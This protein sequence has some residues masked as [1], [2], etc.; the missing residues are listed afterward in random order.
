[1]PL[2]PKGKLMRS[3][4]HDACS[5]AANVLRLNSVSLMMG[6]TIGRTCSSMAGSGH[7]VQ[8]ASDGRQLP[9]PITR[10]Y[11]AS[12]LSRNN[13]VRKAASSR[14]EGNR[15]PLEMARN[16]SPVPTLTAV[17]GRDQKTFM[18]LQFCSEPLCPACQDSGYHTIYMYFAYLAH[19]SPSMNH[20]GRISLLALGSSGLTIMKYRDPMKEVLDKHIKQSTFY[21]YLIK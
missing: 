15:N 2:E 21:G 3:E 1:M 6:V 17:D 5:P 16:W 18:S 13:R 12:T 4:L 9:H 10:R 8:V 7:W 20:I 11:S 14:P 19:L